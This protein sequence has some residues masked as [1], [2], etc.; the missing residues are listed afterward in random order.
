MAYLE[1]QD[2][3]KECDNFTLSA[4]FSVEEG[5]FLCIIGPSGSGKSTL[6]SLIEGLDTP[7]SGSIILDGKDITSERIQD[8]NIG[9]V[10]QDFTLFPSMNVEKNIEYGMKT[11]KKADRKRF[12]SNLLKLVGLEGY[13]K[14]AVTSLSGGEAQ[15]VQLARALAAEPKMLLLDEPLSALDPPLRKSI[16]SAIR[17][18]HDTL[19]ITMLYVTHDR[20]EAFTISDSI[21]IMH[22]G[23]AVAK[24]NAEELY[25]HPESLFT[26]FFTGEGTAIP[27]YLVYENTDGY[28]FFRPEDA[29]LSEEPLDPELYP[30]HVIF[31]DLEVV[32]EAFMGSGY[33]LGM[34]YQGYPMLSLSHTKPRKKHVSLMILAASMQNIAQ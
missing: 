3:T 16:R 13:E 19:G 1:I 29:V 32:S 8:R 11:E 22:D 33:L 24:G 7:S 4:S 14:R 21:L 30:M 17:S 28:L 5:E 10:F 6:L 34:E 20:E 26:A 25:R 23:K 12:A 9:M 15:R 18:I 2:I 27:A 31:N